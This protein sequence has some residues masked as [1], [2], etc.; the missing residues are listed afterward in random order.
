LLHL[1][2]TRW[3]ADLSPIDPE[4]PCDAECVIAKH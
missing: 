2:P 1:Y 3:F 4:R